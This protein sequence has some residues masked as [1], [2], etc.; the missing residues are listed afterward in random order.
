MN[1]KKTY[2]YNLVDF[3]QARFPLQIYKINLNI[4]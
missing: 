3:E 4:Q 2:I 1:E